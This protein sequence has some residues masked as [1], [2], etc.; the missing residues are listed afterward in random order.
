[1]CELFPVHSVITV[2][3]L[4]LSHDSGF[5]T[6]ETVLSSHGQQ[7]TVKDRETKPG[8]VQVCCGIERSQGEIYD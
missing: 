1:M 4:P 3:C 7:A 8:S 2:F 5:K 6:I